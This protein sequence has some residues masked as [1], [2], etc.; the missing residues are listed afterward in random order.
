[1]GTFMAAETLGKYE[2]VRPLAQ[3]GMAEI[4][5]ARQSGPAGFEK[6][7]VIKRVLPH[8][9]ADKD[10]VEMF[11]DEARLAAR[12]SHPNEDGDSP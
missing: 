7:V 2:L 11:L 3:G 10:F 5:L 6:Q 4:F 8:L 12:L 1:M 9:A